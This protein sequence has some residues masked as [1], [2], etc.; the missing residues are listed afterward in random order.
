MNN[1]DFEMIRDA[2]IAVF[3][4]KDLFVLGVLHNVSVNS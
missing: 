1:I 2:Q 4:E 3:L